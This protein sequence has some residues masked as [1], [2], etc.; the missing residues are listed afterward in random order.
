MRPALALPLLPLLFA[1]SR[2]HF[3]H[4]GHLHADATLSVDESK[5]SESQ[6]QQQ[7]LRRDYKQEP[8]IVGSDFYYYVSNTTTGPGQQLAPGVTVRRWDTPHPSTDFAAAAPAMT[9]ID[10]AKGTKGTFFPTPPSAA[11]PAFFFEEA[12]YFVVLGGNISFQAG[13]LAAAC[14]PDQQ[15]L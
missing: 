11:T 4:E 15:Q 6:L 14:A 8:G 7:H 5:T 2:A 3:G 1:P 13:P 10:F 9:R 12:T